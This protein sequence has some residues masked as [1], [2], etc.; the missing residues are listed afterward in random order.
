MPSIRREY[1]IDWLFFV[2]ESTHCPSEGYLQPLQI[3]AMGG[4]AHYLCIDDRLRLFMVEG[5]SFALDFPAI[6][7]QALSRALT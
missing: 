6:V 7:V 5:P 2:Y 4:M 1:P 3:T